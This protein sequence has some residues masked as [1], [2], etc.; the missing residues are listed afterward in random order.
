MTALADSTCEPC[1]SGTGALDRAEAE[2]LISEL[3]D[4]LLSEDA[5][6]I[7]RR[8]ESKGFAKAVQMANLA[9]W[10]GDKNGHHPDICFGWGYCTVTFTTHEAKGLSRNDFICAAKL[11]QIVA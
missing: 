5:T 8:F 3:D 1:K 9:A 11:D 6:A 10:V 2:L 7:S 4:W